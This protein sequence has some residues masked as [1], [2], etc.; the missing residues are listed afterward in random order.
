MPRLRRPPLRSVVTGGF[1]VGVLAVPLAGRAL[2]PVCHPPQTPAELAA[3]LRQYR[4]ALHVITANAAG[5]ENGIYVC[6]RPRLRDEVVGLLR[7][8]DWAGR[9]GGVV[10][11]EHIGPGREIPARELTEWGEHGMRAGPLLYFGDPRLLADLAP[12]VGAEG[13]GR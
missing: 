13:L 11:C 9:W 4:P 10:L 5:P 1:L 7:R 8:R 3:L 6:D 2:R 12:L